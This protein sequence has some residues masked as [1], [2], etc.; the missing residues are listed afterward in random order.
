MTNS[1]SKLPSCV[2]GKVMD[3]EFNKSTVDKQQLINSY[4]YITIRI[5]P[6]NY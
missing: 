3:D 1:Q 5:T 2:I 4:C 6:K